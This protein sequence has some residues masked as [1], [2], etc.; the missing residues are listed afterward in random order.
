MRALQGRSDAARFVLDD[1]V[2][3]V[4][5][6]LAFLRH[7]PAKA[8][9]I[10]DWSGALAV[11]LEAQGSAVTMA[12]DELDLE[13]PYPFGGFDLVACLGMLDTANDLPGALIHIREALAL[14]GFAIASFLG[15]GSLSHLRDA[16][17]AADGERPAA[18]MHPVVDVRAGG[19]LLQRVDWAK[20]VVDSHSI[21]VSYRSLDRLVG[22][23]RAQGL[24][25]VL[26]SSGPAIGKT[27]LETARSV[28]LGGEERVIERFEIITLSGWK[29]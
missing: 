8:L 16:M 2:D 15:A 1:I 3:D 21:P 26:T 13:S 12:D 23:L 5:E 17:F 11:A 6:R 7:R 19:Q 25:N 10:G 9:V 24:G 27:G 4:I 28:F 14:G 20:P 29:V 18:R 22:D